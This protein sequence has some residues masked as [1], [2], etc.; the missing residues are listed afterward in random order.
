MNV[1]NQTMDSITQLG[2]AALVRE[3]G[4]A[5]AIRFINQFR[6]GSGDYTKER[7]QLY[8]GMTVRQLADEIKTKK[9]QS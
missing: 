5:N 7:E 9:S 1:K 6:P 8:E 4:V 3:L 2:M